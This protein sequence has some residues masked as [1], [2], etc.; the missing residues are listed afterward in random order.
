MRWAGWAVVLLAL[1]AGGAYGVHEAGNIADV[2]AEAR[3][4]A[5]AVTQ[6]RARVAALEADLAAHAADA[7]RIGELEAR[8]AAL[9]TRLRA[10][11][12]LYER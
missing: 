1:G 5:A 12:R 2:V 10:A 11:E 9:E 3:E 7:E 4:G 6:L 8:I